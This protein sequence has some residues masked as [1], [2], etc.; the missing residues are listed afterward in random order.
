VAY[1]KVRRRE[2]TTA[3]KLYLPTILAGMKTTMGHL[4]R[5]IGGGSGS[6]T[7]QYPEE[8]HALPDRYRGAP[9]LVKDQAGREKCVSCSLCEYVC[10]PRAISIVPGEIEGPVEK[11]PKAFDIDMLRCI[12]CGYCEEVCPEQAI[13]MSEE[14]ELCGHTREE[15]VFHKDKLY[16]MG[17]RFGRDGRVKDAVRKYDRLVGEAAEQGLDLTK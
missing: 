10:P 9:V 6:V 1:V 4:A 12:F 15:M 17:E 7:M 2:L 5:A 16:A 3:E 14:Y 11:G 13:F 8:K